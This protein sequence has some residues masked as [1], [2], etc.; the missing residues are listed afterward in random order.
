MNQPWLTPYQHQIHG[1]ESFNWIQTLWLDHVRVKIIINVC[2]SYSSFWFQG[3]LLE[4]NIVSIRSN[5]YA[6]ECFKINITYR[7]GSW[8]KV[9]RRPYERLKMFIIADIHWLWCTWLLFFCWLS[10][11]SVGFN[12]CKFSFLDTPSWSKVAASERSRAPPDVSWY[13]SSY[14]L[15]SSSQAAFVTYWLSHVTHLVIG[16]IYSCMQYRM[17][18]YPGSVGTIIFL[19]RPFNCTSS[20]RKG[21]SWRL[22]TSSSAVPLKL[23]VPSTITRS[24]CRES[25]SKTEKPTPSVD[26]VPRN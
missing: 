2:I 7:K 12:F 26:I 23:L 13:V 5:W 1:L 25:T 10:W 15:H 9:Q 24:S 18:R 16:A 3:K 6:S 8:T 19:M 17:S 11:S 14:H 4:I 22:A 21:S 20:S